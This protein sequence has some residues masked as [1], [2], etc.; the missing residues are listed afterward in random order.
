[1]NIVMWFVQPEYFGGL[2]AFLLISGFGIWL[3]V[4]AARG[5]IAFSNGILSVKVPRWLLLLIGLILP[6]PTL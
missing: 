1:M 5:N 6:V 4:R 3:I 2:L